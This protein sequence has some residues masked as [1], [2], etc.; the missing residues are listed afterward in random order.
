[1]LP[2]AGV[3]TEL[4]QFEAESEKKISVVSCVPVKPTQ[5]HDLRN[6]SNLTVCVIVM[7]VCETIKQIAGLLA[8]VKMKC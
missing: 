7:N 8:E 6:I 1:M 2:A 5:E 4:Q 3:C